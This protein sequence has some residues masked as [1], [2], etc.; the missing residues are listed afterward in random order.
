[1]F[2]TITKLPTII[3]NNITHHAVSFVDD[4]TNIVDSS[5]NDTLTNYLT[6]FHC[7]LWIFYMVNKLKINHDK[8]EMLVTCKKRLREATKI[9]TFMA[10][11]FTIS[12]KEYI[13]ILGYTIS[14]DLLPQKQINFTIS[15]CY[16]RL[17]CIRQ[18][19]DIINFK[20]RL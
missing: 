12:Q 15:Q 8:T 3:Y 5:N 17:S 4:T 2:S 19:K 18:V 9:L 14:K 10:G 20:T 7:L 16:Y 13:T 11:Q 6:D 1:M